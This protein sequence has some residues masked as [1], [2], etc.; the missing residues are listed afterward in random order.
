MTPGA[1]RPLPLIPRTNKSGLARSDKLFI[2]FQISAGLV[3]PGSQVSDDQTV[4]YNYSEVS[5]Q[6]FHPTAGWCISYVMSSG[7][8]INDC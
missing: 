1:V 3:G 8:P 6:I 7:S 2:L 5:K 4:D